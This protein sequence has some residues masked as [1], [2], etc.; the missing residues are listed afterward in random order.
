L[1]IARMGD[2]D[3]LKPTSLRAAMDIF[4][5][6]DVAAIILVWFTSIALSSI[7]YWHSYI[8]DIIWLCAPPESQASWEFHLCT[9][10][11]WALMCYAIPICC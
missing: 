8:N 7:S 2:G 9:F 6:E 4:S 1:W 10:S 3:E 11:M 5:D